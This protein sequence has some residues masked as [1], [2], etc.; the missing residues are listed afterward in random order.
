MAS[1]KPKVT[2]TKNEIIFEYDEIELEVVKDKKK[3][4]K[5]FKHKVLTDEDKKELKRKMTEL[6]KSK[7]KKEVK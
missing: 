5:G 3:L 4:P 1:K 7:L 6:A 2:E